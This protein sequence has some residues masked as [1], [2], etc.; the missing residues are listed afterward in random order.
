MAAV[1]PGAEQPSEV[2]NIF[3]RDRATELISKGMI[4]AQFW[5]WEEAEK[6]TTMR[7]GE[8]ELGN[9]IL[10]EMLQTCVACLGYNMEE[11]GE[12]RCSVSTYKVAL[13]AVRKRCIG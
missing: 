13:I 11:D 7:S 12:R 8:S 5:D 9:D 6:R 1:Q 2:L 10:W 3:T 4:L